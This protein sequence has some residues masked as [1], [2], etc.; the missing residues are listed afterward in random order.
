[1]KILYNKKKLL[2]FIEKEKDLGFVPTMGAIHL[3]HI[4][5]IK[6]S[7]LQ[8]DSTIVTIFVNKPQFSR[9]NDYN[10]YPRDL[11]KDINV[12]KRLDIDYLYIPTSKQIY[13][14]GVNNKIKICSFSKKLC[15]RFRPGHF[16]AVVDVIDRFFKIINPKKIYLGEKDMQQL[17][18]I[19]DFAR[20]RYPQIEVVACKSIRNKNGLV[21]SSRNYLLSRKEK[22]IGSLIYKYIKKNK[23]KIINKIISRDEIVNTLIEFGASKVEYID[24]FN[25]S[26]IIKP[27]IKKEHHKIFISY[28]FRNVR[29]IDNI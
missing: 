19:E 27:Y 26:K 1:M 14:N 3:G 8:N 17:K 5:L 28:Y 24:V 11:K 23:Y 9:K 22:K 20:R 2:K 13:P 6:K 10:K 21:F 15:G 16:N 25:L 4:S 12:L 18:I 7:I 29:L